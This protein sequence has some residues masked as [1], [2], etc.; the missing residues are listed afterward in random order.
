MPEK[1]ELLALFYGDWCLKCGD[2]DNL[3]SDHV[4]PKRL[5]GRDHISNLQI[6]CERCKAN[7]KMIDYRHDK[8]AHFDD[9]LSRTKTG[10]RA[11]LAGQP[12]VDPQFPKYTK[13]KKV[14]KPKPASNPQPTPEPK[15]KLYYVHDPIE[16]Q[17]HLDSL[18]P[19]DKE[20][21]VVINNHPYRMI[22]RD[23]ERW[24]KNQSPSLQNP[25]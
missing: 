12:D 14:K 9:G 19:K 4:I 23:D 5:D 11:I 7:I 21:I 13:R 22:T 24:A 10:K 2:Q 8:G 17:K 3:T 6:L 16:A 25:G 18:H 1:R 20:S 15:S